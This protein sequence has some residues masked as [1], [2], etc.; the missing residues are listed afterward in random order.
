MGRTNIFSEEREEYIFHTLKQKGKVTIDELCDYFKVSKSTIRKQLN[1]LETTGALTRTHGGAIISD[2]LLEEYADKKSV[3]NRLEKKAITQAAKQFVQD[4]DI[5]AIGG[6]STLQE[7]SLV[8]KDLKDSVVVTNSILVAADL[9]QN[10]NIDV[11]IC[12]GVV[13]GRSGCVVGKQAEAYFENI[14][15]Q[16]MF[17]GADG[18]CLDLGISSANLLVAQVESNMIKCA[19]ELYVLADHTKMGKVSL[20]KQIDLE[21]VTC[22]ITDSGADPDF[23]EKLREK[24]GRVVVADFME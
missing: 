8:L 23:I 4:G 24:I 11:R 2:Q 10:K 22:L 3:S 21:R 15:V 20:A 19:D 12:G 16:K 6:G 9:M 14:H 7:M 17:I 13:N 1:Y 18:V 5:V